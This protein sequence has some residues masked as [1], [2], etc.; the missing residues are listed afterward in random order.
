MDH[1]NSQYLIYRSCILG[2]QK[3]DQIHIQFHIQRNVVPFVTS[4]ENPSSLLL[5]CSYSPG[6]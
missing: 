1:P 3:T 6:Q 5:A 2:M 4:L